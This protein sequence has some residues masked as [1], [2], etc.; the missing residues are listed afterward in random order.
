MA[1]FQERILIMV[2]T[3]VKGAE[4]MQG[5]IAAQERFNERIKET[6]KGMRSLLMPMLGV[7]F[8]GMALQRTFLGLLQPVM[9]AYGVFELFS[10]MLL[11]LFIPIMEVLFP[12]FLQMIDYFMSLPESVQF[13]IGVIAVL[14][15]I[16]GTL[17][18]VLGQVIIGFM[19]LGEGALLFGHKLAGVFTILGKIVWILLLFDGLRRIIT[20]FGESWSQV[21]IGIGEVSLA[22]GLLTK[23]FNP[24]MLAIGLAIGAFGLMIEISRWGLKQQGLEYKNTWSMI[25]GVVID[26][27]VGII[28]TL[29]F[30]SQTVLIVGKAIWT[31]FSGLFKSIAAGFMSALRGESFAEGF[32]SSWSNAIN[33]V[34]SDILNLGED[35]NFIGQT[36]IKLKSSLGLVQPIASTSSSQASNL[37]SAL[38]PN[39]SNLESANI[40]QNVTNN[41]QVMDKNEFQRMLDE[42]NRKMLEQMRTMS[43]A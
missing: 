10:T 31:V 19:A 35:I 2:E 23:S 13:V 15:V 34:K 7:M 41:V 38:S 12:L 27:I 26:A 25:A 28:G 11:V 6:Q 4:K 22:I 21:A 1:T 17:L 14:G 32:K 5:Q 9:D 40:T 20:E 42:N 29:W 8:F 33:S 37:A 24:L 43:R 3:L 18:S 36:G 39:R 30:L 16:L